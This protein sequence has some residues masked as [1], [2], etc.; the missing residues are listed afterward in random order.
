MIREVLPLIHEGRMPRTPQDHSLATE[1]PTRRPEDG[2]VDWMRTT[3]QLH[4]WVRALTHPYP[5]AFTWLDRRRVFIWEASR[6]R[7]GPG[8]SG[9]GM[10]SWGATVHAAGLLGSQ[11]AGFTFCELQP[12]LLR[13]W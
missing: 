3:R 1:M 13:C 8:V 10:C 2:L 6:W 7:P 5:G 9:R 12:L 11:E 4:D